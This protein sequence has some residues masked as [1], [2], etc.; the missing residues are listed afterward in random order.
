MTAAGDI[1]DQA[2][3][4]REAFDTSF[5]LPR[6]AGAT[7]A[8]DLLAIRV[9][10]DA[11]AMRLRDIGGIVARPTVM[12][13]PAAAP[14]VLGIAGVRGEIVPVYRLADFL[15]YVDDPDQSAWMA[16]CS[17]EQAVA[18]CF[19]QL[20][21]L[22]RLPTAALHPGGDRL[23]AHAPRGAYLT[24]L[25]TT[26]TGARPIVAVPLIVAAIRDRRAARNLGAST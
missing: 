8:E 23:T 4:L 3:A 25:A 7:G 13:V 18:L 15:G 22:L 19:S 12:P 20:E 1:E 5:S 26:E 24:E 10:G 17:G 9:G 6:L 11:Y 21:G 16:L 2:R 14:G